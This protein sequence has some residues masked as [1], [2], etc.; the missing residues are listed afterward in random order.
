MEESK[1]RLI[2]VIIDK[3]HQSSIIN[4]RTYRV[5]VG[6]SDHYLVVA[7]FSLKLSAKWKRHQQISKNTKL[8]RDKIKSDAEIKTFKLKVSMDF[9]K[10]NAIQSKAGKTSTS[11]WEKIKDS[12]TKAA[13]RL[14]VGKTRRKNH[15]FNHECQKAIKK[16]Q[17]ARTIMTQDPTNDNVENY[18]R[19]RNVANKLIK[20]HNRISEKKKLEEMEIY[21]E[22]PKLFFEKF[23]SIKEGFK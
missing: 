6:D 4:V 13:E 20:L 14:R 18:I 17:E 11:T 19:L 8:D 2:N 16:R 7:K 3:R 23:K 15:W 9:A 21:K 12:L 10:Y 5:T 1:L 22:D